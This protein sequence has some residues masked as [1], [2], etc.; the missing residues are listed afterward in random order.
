MQN[1][2]GEAGLD[3]AEFYLHRFR[4]TFCN[5]HLRR[6][7]DVGTVSAWAGHADLATTALY[8]KAIKSKSAETKAMVDQVWSRLEAGK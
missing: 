1:A 2:V 4:H 3:P 7:V 8:L 6:G 5:T